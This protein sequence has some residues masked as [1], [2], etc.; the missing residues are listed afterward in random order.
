MDCTPSLEEMAVLKK[1]GLQGKAQHCVSV[2][3]R[4]G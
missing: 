4:A 3:L 1:E 2:C